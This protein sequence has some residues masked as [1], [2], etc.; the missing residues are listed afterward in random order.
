MSEKVEKEVKEEEVK[1]ENTTEEEVD[2]SKVKELEKASETLNKILK[3]NELDDVDGLIELISS[4][5]AIK[6]K[7]KNIDSL[8]SIIERSKRLEQYEAYW[9][10]QKERQKR[11]DE[12]PEETIRRLESKLS[13][14]DREKKEK[15]EKDRIAEESRKAIAFFEKTAKKMINESD[16]PTEK[17]KMIS[18]FL[19]INNKVNNIDILDKSS[20]KN[21][22]TDTVKLFEDYDQWIIKK[23]L[24]GKSDVP[25]IP[26]SGDTV[27]ED[28]KPVKTLKEARTIMKERLSSILK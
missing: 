21:V 5:K 24:E 26:K 8:D 3:D 7:V 16:I 27:V 13:E 12:L 20:I 11:E 4:G 6:G 28:E 15:E 18:A 22:F 2:T 10:D 23:Y 1:K 25:V 9:E 17:E 19:G 14:R